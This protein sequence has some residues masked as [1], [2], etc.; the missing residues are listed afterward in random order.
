MRTRT[1]QQST[2]SLT[3]RTVGT[4]LAVLALLTACNGPERGLQGQQVP[5]AALRPDADEL[6][7]AMLAPAGPDTVATAVAALPKAATS[8]TR[9]V[10]NPHGGTGEVTTLRYPGLDVTIYRAGEGLPP[11][12]VGAKMTSGAAP[13]HG[14]TIGMDAEAALQLFA[15]ARV[16]PTTPGASLSLSVEDVPLSAPFQVDLTLDGGKLVAI[17]YHAY[18]D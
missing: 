9:Q 1:Y 3:A 4:A 11:L 17:A 12:L 14:V 2:R 15:T 8:D 10:A 7:D 6:L 5:T 18:L 16:L 13:A